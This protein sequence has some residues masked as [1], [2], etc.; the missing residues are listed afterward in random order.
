MA[1]QLSSRMQQ[2][3]MAARRSPA[4]ALPASRTTVRTAVLANNQHQQTRSVLSAVAVPSTRCWHCLQ[5]RQPSNRPGVC[6]C[7]VQAG[8]RCEGRPCTGAQ[9]PV[10]VSHA[11]L[12]A[13]RDGW[14]AGELV[15]VLRMARAVLATD[16]QQQQHQRQRRQEQAMG[17]HCHTALK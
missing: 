8:M 13:A 6:L 3:P 12:R 4:S 16:Q 1:L 9:H 15:P 2:R 5:T 17:G 14:N 11:I 10:D 7:G